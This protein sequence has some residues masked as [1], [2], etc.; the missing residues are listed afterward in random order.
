MQDKEKTVAS[1]PNLDS[2][3]N[4]APSESWLSIYPFLKP[5]QEEIC[6]LCQ[7]MQNRKSGRYKGKFTDNVIIK[8][9]IVGNP[10]LSKSTY[11]EMVKVL[12]NNGFLV[13][14]KTSFLFTEKGWKLY[15]SIKKANF[16]P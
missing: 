7:F 15:W 9:V 6:G 4:L 5:F 8:N 11:R 1:S 10:S 3:Q 2:S 12:L 16:R 13:K 14:E